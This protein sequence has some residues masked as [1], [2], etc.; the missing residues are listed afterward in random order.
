[1]N[2]MC[3]KNTNFYYAEKNGAASA[4][5]FIV[6]HTTTWATSSNVIEFVMDNCYIDLVSTGTISTFV[7]T[8]ISHVAASATDACYLS[9]R[10]DTVTITNTTMPMK[11]FCGPGFLR[12]YADKLSLD[13]INFYMTGASSA[14]FPTYLVRATSAVSAS[15][16]RSYVT[17]LASG[18]VSYGV[19]INSPITNI[20]DSDVTSSASPLYIT[21]TNIAR[22]NISN[23]R[24]VGVGHASHQCMIFSTG[25]VLDTSVSGSSFD[26][27][28]LYVTGTDVLITVSN[29]RMT[30]DAASQDTNAYGMLL[31]ATG[32]LFHTVSGNIINTDT[33][34]PDGAH[35]L[36]TATDASLLGS[37]F[38]NI[39][40]GS[41]NIKVSANGAALTNVAYHVGYAASAI[42]LLPTPGPT[43]MLFNVAKLV[44]P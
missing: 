30:N 20:R 21:S 1:V 11:T 28:S 19:Y 29:N 32:K 8:S 24:V 38:G 12:T 27:C 42:G 3:F 15:V 34:W 25:Y 40:S 18:V 26:G 39:L 4:I 9:V 22:A 7:P 23:S 41:T 36:T 37:C 16:D 10:A 17:C 31:S 13:G 44:T 2:R 5:G 14:S 35:I 43:A 33:G 6:A